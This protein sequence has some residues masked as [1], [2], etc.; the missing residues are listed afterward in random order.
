MQVAGVQ[1]L[2]TDQET[3]RRDMYEMQGTDKVTHGLFRV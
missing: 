1:D 2:G 3:G